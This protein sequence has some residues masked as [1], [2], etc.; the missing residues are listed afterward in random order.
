[1]PCMHSGVSMIFQ[2]TNFHLSGIPIF[3]MAFERCFRK[4]QRHQL[5]PLNFV[6]GLALLIVIAERIGCGESP[7]FLFEMR[8][9]PGTFHQ[10]RV[11][12]LRFLA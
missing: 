5:P 12:I 10:K 2:A 6:A 11:D 7:H 3:S 4:E 9:K 8:L 1:M